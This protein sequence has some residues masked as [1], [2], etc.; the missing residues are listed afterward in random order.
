MLKS[1]EISS[2]TLCMILLY[3]PNL[4]P[5]T[6][7]T[8]SSISHKNTEVL[9]NLTTWKPT[10]KLKFSLNLN[11]GFMNKNEKEKKNISKKFRPSF[12]TKRKLKVKN[13]TTLSGKGEMK[14]SSSSNL[15][16]K[17]KNMLPITRFYMTCVILTT[18]IGQILGDDITQEFLSLD[19]YR[20]LYGLEF[21]RPITAVCFLGPPS[22]GWLFSCYY[23]F[24]YGSSLEKSY[25]TS[26]HFVFLL[27]QIMIL[28]MISPIFNLTFFTPCMITSML[29]VLS[30][31]M[32]N[33]VVKWLIFTVPY[34]L[35]PYGLMISDMLQTGS[36][37]SAIPHVLGLL[38][39]H[40]YYFHKFI[41]PE[42]GGIDWLKAPVIF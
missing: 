14:K 15:L 1:K 25:G 29:H 21:W 12:D 8:F 10:K 16:T 34:W 37:V 20:F 22:I 18:L 5:I 24:N 39:G 30:R 35:L 36:L 11:G 31:T 19:Y 32:P 33:Q 23:L 6:L 9:I 13:Y 26:Q 17:Y 28:S 40:F 42:I 4:L 7:A 41:W 2:V 38:S 27:S 3:S